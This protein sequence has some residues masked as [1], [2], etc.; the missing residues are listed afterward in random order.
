MSNQESIGVSQSTHATSAAESARLSYL[1]ARDAAQQ[2]VGEVRN[3]ASDYLE[4]G[5]AKAADVQV[6][7]QDTVREHPI[8]TILI[9]A[10]AGL[11]LGMLLRRR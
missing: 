4:Q 10:G 1:H 8:K 6:K 2:V 11:L 3:R 5:K 7:I 9:A